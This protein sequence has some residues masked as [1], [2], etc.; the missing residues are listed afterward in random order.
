VHLLATAGAALFF[1]TL[2]SC[3]G[4]SSETPPPLEPLPAN[5]KYSRAA[6]TLPGELGTPV[7]PA[8][9]AAPEG[10]D[11]EPASNGSSAPATKP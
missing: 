4:S 1:V 5:V 3:G 11:A 10:P 6:T 2:A 7:K 8:S 9:N